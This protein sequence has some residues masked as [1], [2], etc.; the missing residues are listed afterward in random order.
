MSDPT[1]T[2]YDPIVISS[3]TP[4]F[5]NPTIILPTDQSYAEYIITGYQWT[6]NGVDIECKTLNTYTVPLAYTYD[7]GTY[8]LCVTYMYSLI[9]NNIIVSTYGSTCLPEILITVLDPIINV[10]VISNNYTVPITSPNNNFTLTAYISGSSPVYT[11]YTPSNHT[12]IIT[13]SN[14]Y[15]INPATLINEGNYYVTVTNAISSFTSAQIY[16]NMVEM[17]AITTQPLRQY[18]IRGKYATFNVIASSKYLTY[19][20]YKGAVPIVGAILSTYTR[21]G[22]VDNELYTVYVSN[23]AGTVISNSILLTVYS[24]V[25][26]YDF[27]VTNDNKLQDIVNPDSYINVIYNRPVLLSVTFPNA[28]ASIY[29]Y[30]WEKDGIALSHQPNSHEYYITKADITNIGDYTVTVISPADIKSVISDIAK[31][32]VIS[33]PIIV[34]DITPLTQKV[35]VLQLPFTIEP[36][37]NNT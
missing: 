6:K 28:D 1:I 32:R 14:T 12:G 3:N 30:R 31:I 5:L 23:V 10:T 11:W 4:L 9:I 13:S 33:G 35:I 16:I 36:C 18:V 20:W 8:A 17:P 37:A 24:S 2:Q 27:N 25:I 21:I 22:L 19:Q 26:V 29:T 15:T 7:S 34:S